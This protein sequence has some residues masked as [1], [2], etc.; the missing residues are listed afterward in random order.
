MHSGKGKEKNIL[1]TLARECFYNLKD[2]LF[3]PPKSLDQVYAFYQLAR[4]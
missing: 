3:I 2:E 4:V 1:S